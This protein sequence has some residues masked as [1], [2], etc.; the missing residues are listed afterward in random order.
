MTLA[1]SGKTIARWECDTCGRTWPP[2][3]TIAVGHADGWHVSARPMSECQIGPRAYDTR[4][5]GIP[6]Q[7]TYAEVTDA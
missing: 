6:V 3:G 4:C 7:R 2:G 1:P 5:F